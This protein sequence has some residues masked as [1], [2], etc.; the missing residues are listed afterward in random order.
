M[1]RSR[2]YLLACIGGLIGFAPVHAQDFELANVAVTATRTNEEVAHVPA[3][4]SV[5]TAEEIAR[6]PAQNISDILSHLPAAYQVPTSDGELSIRGFSTKDVLVL[7]DGQPLNSGWDGAVD[8]QSI[9][10]DNI[11]RIEIVRGAGSS[12]YGGRAVG[13]VVHII[14]KSPRAGFSGSAQYGY[15]SHHTQHA[16]LHLQGG[17]EHWQLGLGYEKQS[18]DGYRSFY[19]EKTGSRKLK[20]P[21]A[22]TLTLP[23]SARNR[24]II[25]GRGEKSTARE[26]YHFQLSHNWD[27]QHRLQYRFSHTEHEYSYHHPFT[28]LHG[29]DGQEFYAGV[30]ATPNGDKFSVDPA[31]F[32]GHLGEYSLNTHRLSYTDDNAQLEAHLGYTEYTRQGYSTPAAITRNINYSELS[33]WDG[34]GTYS[35]YPSK[36]WDFDLH[37]TWLIG[38]H[39][40]TGGANY[41]REEFAQTRYNSLAWRDQTHGLTATE[42]N[43]GRGVDLA[44]Y[45][46]DQY[47]WTDRLK[48]HLGVRFDHYTKSDGYHDTLQQN[49]WNNHHYPANTYT[50]WSPKVALEYRINEQ[51]NAYISFAHSFQPPILYR[52]YRASTNYIPN[53]QLGPE[54]SNTWEVGWKHTADRLSWGFTAFHVNTKNRVLVSTIDTK[55]KISQYTNHPGYLNNSGV[56]LDAKYQFSPS[57]SGYLN[58]TWQETKDSESKVTTHKSLAPSSLN[59]KHLLHVGLEYQHKKWDVLLDAT[60]VS[61]RQAPDAVT[62]VYQSQDAYLITNLTANYQIKKGLTLQGQVYNLFNRQF[63]AGETA[64]DRSYQLSLRY[65]F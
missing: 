33:G 49:K 1:K 65:Q 22:A 53:P 31:E 50:E 48:L 36:T 42:Y 34:P 17:N 8:W 52:V 12:L 4:V 23:T 35:F 60:Y 25:G 62:G 26:S 64:R 16:S 37:K 59:P 14:T 51:N 58:Y 38:A 27:S 57:W 45:L 47:Q 44:L 7:L 15:G 43:G 9:P 19:I 3:A 5:I 2:L 40:L 56:E 29:R 28:Y 24:Y 30:F 18:T 63:F 32:L 11:E 10:T 21:A 39:T 55:K 6:R 61:A 41:H 13:A 46:Q 20:Q 54:T